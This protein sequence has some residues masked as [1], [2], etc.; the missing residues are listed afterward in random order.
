MNISNG[1][2]VKEDTIILKK[3]V[4]FMKIEIECESNIISIEKKS[5]LLQNTEMVRIVH[6]G[7][8]F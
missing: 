8:Y 1:N 4:L 5:K 6:K 7:K 3:P 2:V